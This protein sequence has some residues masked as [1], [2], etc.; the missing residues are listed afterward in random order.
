MSDR[1]IE[2]PG[3]WSQADTE[4][5]EEA[6]AGSLTDQARNELLGYITHNLLDALD[7]VAPVVEAAREYT[8]GPST[9]IASAWD[10]LCETLRDLAFAKEEA[11]DE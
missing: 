7:A 10:R 11:T 4:A 3:V 6:L 8:T 1:K 5:A 9:A 2:I